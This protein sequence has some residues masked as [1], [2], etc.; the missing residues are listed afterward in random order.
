MGYTEG[1]EIIIPSACGLVLDMRHTILGPA[2]TIS[3]LSDDA[4]ADSLV[5][6]LWKRM[7]E[8]PAIIACAYCTAHNAYTN[9]VCVQCGGPM[10]TK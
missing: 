3:N 6:K 9:P 5:E 1:P 2:R 7:F 4:L 8:K 10:G